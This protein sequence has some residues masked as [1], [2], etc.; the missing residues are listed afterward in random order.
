MNLKRNAITPE[1]QVKASRCRRLIFLF[2][3]FFLLTGSAAVTD[4]SAENGKIAYALGNSIY[5]MNADGT[6]V[7]QLTFNI[8]YNRDFSPVWSPNGL[9]IAFVRMISEPAGGPNDYD[10]T[11]YNTTYGI[12]TVDYDGANLTQIKG[13]AAFVNDLTWSPDGT[14]LAYVQG[15]DTT[16]AGRL[17]NCSGNSYIYTVNA[18][19]NGTTRRITETAG[20]IDPSWS[21]DGTKIYFAVNNN[22][23]TYGIYSYNIATDDVSQLTYD[24]VPPADPEISPDGASIA[25]AVNY[26]EDQCIAGNMSTMGPTRIHF[27]R[28]SLI[29]YNIA[30]GSSLVA[31]YGGASNP[32]W[33]PNGSLILFT[34]AGNS[35]MGELELSTITP[36]GLNQTVIQNGEAGEISGSWSP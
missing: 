10:S 6:G 31:A 16:F 24:T 27:Y 35:E 14:K 8:G 17:Q 7:Q 20:G 4:V 3:A 5:K 33:H 28:G 9:K 30:A 2:L 36:A 22:P 34:T 23:E 18:V 1:A 29:V 19:P 11:N 13:G 32:S 15:A 12:Y 26:N 21:P 25:Y